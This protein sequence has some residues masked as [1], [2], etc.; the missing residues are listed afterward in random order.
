MDQLLLLISRYKE[1][2]QTKN[3]DTNCVVVIQSLFLLFRYF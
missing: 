1:R 2:F 3:A